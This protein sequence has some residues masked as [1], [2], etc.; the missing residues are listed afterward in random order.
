MEQSV[1]AL[2]ENIQKHFRDHAFIMLAELES[3]Q[4]SVIL[5]EGDDPSSGS[6]IRVAESHNP[7][8]YSILAEEIANRY[9]YIRKRKRNSYKNKTGGSI[10]KRV[11]NA[12]TRISEGKDKAYNGHQYLYDTKLR[13][14]I[15]ERLVDG[16]AIFV[17]G[18]LYAHQ[19][20]EGEVVAHFNE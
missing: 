10:R 11:K 9:S 12:L 20:P 4:L 7:K 13:E 1:D 16:Y 6:R 5:I 8:W 15:L 2:P 18:Y 17:E 3:N 19:E 14:L